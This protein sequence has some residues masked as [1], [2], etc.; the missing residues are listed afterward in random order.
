MNEQKTKK[1]GS[2][3][4]GTIVFYVLAGLLLFYILLEL[5]I[6]SVTIKVFQFKPYVVIT[7][8]MEPVLNVN[9][10]V[11]V[12]N[13]NLDK[14]EV[15]DI[16]TFKADINYDGEKEVITHYINAIEEDVDGD[17]IFRTNR[18]GSTVPDTWI[19]HDSDVIGVYGFRIP[20]MGM[21][22]NFV[23]SPFGIAAVSV[24]L[25]I[26]GVIIFLVKSGKKE[27][28]NKI[29]NKDVK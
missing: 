24:N 19:L 14:L 20:Q 4:V 16:I 23:K 18:Y 13:P 29:E 2:K 26:I 6:P 15:G 9:D 10:M 28:D 8:S 12:V 5:F 7:E 21:F 27:T 11:V 22:I 25:I 17:R 1:N 3:L